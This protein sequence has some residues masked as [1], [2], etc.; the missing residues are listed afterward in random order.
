MK[1][2]LLKDNEGKDIT[3]YLEGDELTLNS[4]RFYLT[5]KQKKEIEQKYI[6][7][8]KKRYYIEKIEEVK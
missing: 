3:A 5:P 6:N 7:I 2:I 1:K 8:G 4:F